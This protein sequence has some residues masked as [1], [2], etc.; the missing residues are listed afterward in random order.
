[1]EL[2]IHH[3]LPWLTVLVC[4]VAYGWC[5]YAIG[6]KA[7]QDVVHE[8]YAEYDP[9]IPTFLKQQAD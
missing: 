1:M 3:I 6:Y 7:G 9:D 5:M 8:W 2:F 4:V